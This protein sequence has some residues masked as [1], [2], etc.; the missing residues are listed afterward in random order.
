[1]NRPLDSGGMDHIDLRIV[2]L[3][4]WS[5]HNPADARRGLLNP[6][7]VAA[8]L[9]VHG[10]SVKRRIRAMK[11]SGVLRGVYLIPAPTLLGQHGAAQR[12]S[13]R[14]T[15]AKADAV[16]ALGAHAVTPEGKGVLAVFSFVGN[17]VWILASVPVVQDLDHYIDGLAHELGAVRS[18]RIED[19]SWGPDPEHVTSLDREIMSALVHDALLTPPQVAK[20]VGV[21]PKTVRARLAH[22]VGLG[23]FSIEPHEQSSQLHGAFPL[24]LVAYP[25]S[26]RE[27]EVA[28]ALS[29]AF[30]EA[31][32]RCSPWARRPFVTVPVTNM[33]TMD[34]VLELA[35]SLR[36]VDHVESS[37][38]QGRT[39]NREVHEGLHPLAHLVRKPAT[40]KAPLVVARSSSQGRRVQMDDR[41]N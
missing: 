6:W 36:G 31:V 40:G 20:E 21:T 2:R 23:A 28:L 33:Q 18:E 7:D 41:L 16:K 39:C 14:D 24:T 26:G 34:G 15:R 38:L 12:L 3:L 32:H 4:T 37:F 17:D 1:M 27:R 13:F 11:Q 5:P 10:T 8:E 25:E 35:Q 9:G 30:P 19:Y 29:N 22:L